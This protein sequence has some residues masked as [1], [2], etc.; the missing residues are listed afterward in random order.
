MQTSLLRPYFRYA[1]LP[2]EKFAEPHF[3]LTPE[4]VVQLR[5]MDYF[6]QWKA[7]IENG[8]HH[9]L[10]EDLSFFSFSNLNERPSY[11]YSP[12]PLEIESFRTFL[13]LRDLEPSRS[14][15][16]AYK[17]EYQLALETASLKEHLSPI[18]YDVDPHGYEPATHPV[19][20]I[21]IG[22]NNQIRIGTRRLITPIAFVLFVIRQFFPDN[23]RNLL[24][25]QAELK[26]ERNI[27]T[28]LSLIDQQFWS[29]EDELQMY[30]Q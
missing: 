10:L 17:E 12:C 9:V 26:I 11:S 16:D 21:H 28:K 8:W 1:G 22:L 4:I 6:H 13:L 24:Q 3:E 23:W 20:H 19:A 30:L 14:N 25:Y 2:V 27:R 5:Q 7:C 15:R 18:R 29:Q